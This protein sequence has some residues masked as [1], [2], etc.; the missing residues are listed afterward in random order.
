MGTDIE[1]VKAQI[2]KQEPKT[3]IQDIIFSQAEQFKHC[4]PSHITPER[5]CRVAL[6]N[7][8]LNP[9]LADCS[10][11]S[12]IAALFQSAQLGLEPGI[13]GQAYLIPYKNSKKINGQWVTKMEVQFQIGYKGLVELCY[14]YDGT[15]TL[16]MQ[17]VCEND[18]FEY[19]LG[20][21]GYIKHKPALT[22]RGNTIAYYA[23][24]KFKNGD[25]LF[26]IMSKEECI[27]HA[28]KH[29]K[30]YDK[31]TGTF[32]GVWADEEDAMC[33]KTVLIQLMKTMPKSI[34]VKRALAAD[35]TTKT[36]IS[37]DMIEIKDETNWE[38]E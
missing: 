28:K 4:L 29:S 12:F 35:N 27:E 2:I 23:V 10:V 9:K 25:K 34:E 6:T 1:T 15:S 3:T 18:V 24:A 20:T 8:R 17:K 26:N 11:E 38:N 36:R 21:D 31:S 14:R 5:M 32:S 16:D 30:T 22:N 37:E 13:E 7:Y 19:E 33:K